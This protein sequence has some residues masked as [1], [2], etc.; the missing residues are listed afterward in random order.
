MSAIPLV[1]TTAI[2]PLVKFLN[3]SG[4]PTEKFLRQVKLP[5]DTL[6]NSESLIPLYYGFDFVEKVAKAEGIEHLGILASQKVKV[7]DFGVFGNI[8]SQSLTLYDLLQTISQ[9]LTKTHNSGARTWVSEKGDRIWFN[10]QYINPSRVYN[11]QSQYYAC[12]NYLEIIHSITGGGWHPTDLY[13]QTGPVQGLENLELFSKVRVHFH[14]ANNAI[15]FPKTQLFLPIRRTENPFL[16]PQQEDYE[17]LLS[18][19]PPT[20]LKTSLQVFIRSRL[21]DGHPDIQTA[22]SAA[23]MSLR[24][25]QRRL[26]SEKLIYSK[27]VE[28]TRFDLAVSMLQDPAIRLIDI[29]VELGYSDAAK[30]TRAFKRWTGITPSEF[31]LKVYLATD[32]VGEYMT[33]YLT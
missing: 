3:Q 22:A 1:R 30:F 6:D 9:L 11:R 25:F 20:D 5:I 8:V 14:Q 19:A 21:L 4:V 16:S 28:Q 17:H 10:H 13:F 15:G 27:L 26:A 24:S 23:G 7:N 29:A 12:L 31:R 2:L 18:S 32:T 33:R